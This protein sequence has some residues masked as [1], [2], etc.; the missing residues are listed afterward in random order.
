MSAPV[1]LEIAP[2]FASLILDRPER[3]NALNRAIWEA[4]PALL[5][6]AVGD[7]AVKVLFVSGA[8]TEAFAAGADIGEFL[9][10]IDTG[11]AADYG[12]CME[13]ATRAL[14]AFA[15]PTVAVIR[16]AC[17]GGG[18]SLALCCDFR[19][20][21]DSARFG[22]PPARLGIAYPL[23]DTKRLIDTVGLAAARKLL[24]IGRILDAAEARAIGLVDHIF[25]P[26]LLVTEA[27]R[28]GQH[29]ADLSQFSLRATKT[30][31]AQILAGA[32]AETEISRQL[33]AEGFSGPDLAEGASAFLEKRRPRF[34]FS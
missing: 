15:K 14:A 12:A 23:E 10:L 5:D 11:G 21:D 34:T 3:L 31:I 20:A 1:R 13:R 30:V 7:P 16:G 17:F 18:C 22:I 24:M 32:T 28:F 8:G 26:G 4:I 29:L 33:W 25:A 2:P 27:D 6:Q 9:D 19:L